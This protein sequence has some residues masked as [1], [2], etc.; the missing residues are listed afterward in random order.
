MRRLLL[1][2][3]A[4]VGCCSLQ[5]QSFEEWHDAELNQINRA[6]M[7]SSFKVFT[8]AER[9]EGAYCDTD[10]PYRLSLNGEWAFHFA[11]NAD[12]RAK[13]FFAVGYD[14]SAW[15]LITVPAVWETE[16]RT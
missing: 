8:S 6:P 14:D 2:T 13:D 5:A 10:N 3:L 1:L 11:E 16:Y 15:E 12:Q 4:I 9:A 7:H